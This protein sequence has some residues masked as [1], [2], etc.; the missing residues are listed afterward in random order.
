VAVLDQE[1]GVNPSQR[2]AR[3]GL[4]VRAVISISEIL[5][6]IDGGHNLSKL[7]TIG[8]AIAALPRSFTCV[9]AMTAFIR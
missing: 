3:G 1:L 6:M 5:L 9:S 2:A 4:Q 7:Q 8:E